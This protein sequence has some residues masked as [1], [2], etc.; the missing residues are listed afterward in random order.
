[1]AVRVLKATCVNH[2]N[3][4]YQLEFWADNISECVAPGN[5]SMVGGSSATVTNSNG[6]KLYKYNGATNEWKEDSNGFVL[7]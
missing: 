3:N 1:M 2:A 5:M 6:V 7:T 4:E